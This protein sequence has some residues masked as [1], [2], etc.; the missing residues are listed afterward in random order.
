MRCELSTGGESSVPYTETIGIKT[1]NPKKK[2][3]VRV[4]VRVRV[5]VGSD[6]TSP[7][8]YRVN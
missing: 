1:K 6:G 4:R 5:R 3:K 7:G 8:F 2:K